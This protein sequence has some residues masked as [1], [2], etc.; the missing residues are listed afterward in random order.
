MLYWNTKIRWFRSISKLVRG[1]G[2]VDWASEVVAHTHTQGFSKL[3]TI[4][5]P[6]NYVI[7]KRCWPSS[8]QHL[9][10]SNPIMAIKYTLTHTSSHTST[11]H[12]HTHTHR[13]AHTCRQ[14]NQQNKLDKHYDN[15][16]NN[17]D[18]RICSSLFCVG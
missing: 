1:F 8:A 5:T 13:Y 7:N 14:L 17:S 11:R 4:F 15:L 10:H 9:T 6:N 2:I 12:S 3:L 16:N 18:Y